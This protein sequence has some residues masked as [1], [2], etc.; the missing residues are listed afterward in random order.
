MSIKAKG[1]DKDA[2]LA[3]RKQITDVQNQVIG[4]LAG[5]RYKISTK[6]EII[7]TFAMEVGPLPL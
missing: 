3:Q 4:E 1:L 2:E 7:P 6:F 5:T